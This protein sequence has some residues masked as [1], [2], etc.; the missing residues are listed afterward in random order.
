M[1][2]KPNGSKSHPFDEQT[3]KPVAVRER[4]KKE[5]EEEEGQDCNSCSS[6]SSS[7]SLSSYDTDNLTDTT[8]TTSPLLSPS[9]QSINN[10][11]SRNSNTKASSNFNR[12]V[13]FIIIVCAVGLYLGFSSIVYEQTLQQQ[14]QAD[15]CCCNS[16][17]DK[18][19]YCCD[20]LLLDKDNKRLSLF[21]HNHKGKSIEKTKTAILSQYTKNKEKTEIRP[22]N[23]HFSSPL[24]RMEA[25]VSFITKLNEILHLDTDNIET[26]KH[27]HDFRNSSQIHRDLMQ[28]VKKCPTTVFVFHLYNVTSPQV[29]PTLSEMFP[30]TS[31]LVDT[32]Y[33]EKILGGDFS[34]SN[35]EYSI[36]KRSIFI[37][38][39]DLGQSEI[40]NSNNKLT[41]FDKEV[42][43]NNAAKEHLSHRF[44]HRIRS[45]IPLND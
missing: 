27:I 39:S 28:Q 40:N 16:G 38:L 34:M 14:Q 31:Y 7:D 35:Q 43:V 20:L 3:T 41:Y 21:Y 45:V 11:T 37:F 9:N 12:Y 29:Q 26:L 8:D 17:L 32:G 10:S 15:D 4:V 42:I 2:S 1:R 19:D 18:D 30:N 5:E 36:Y 23:I 6:S 13:T 33:L 25:S 24:D 22:L 44:V